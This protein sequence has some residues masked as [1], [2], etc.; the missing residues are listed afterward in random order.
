MQWCLAGRQD[1][2]AMDGSWGD[3]LP[4]VHVGV[5]LLE[6]RD[7]D[8]GSDVVR[9]ETLLELVQ[10]GRHQGCGEGLQTHSTHGTSTYGDVS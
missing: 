7:R 2:G 5:G 4:Q 1:P 8:V 10:P 9:G 6:L 3:R